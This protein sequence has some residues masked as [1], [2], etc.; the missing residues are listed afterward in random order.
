[1]YKTRVSCTFGSIHFFI[2]SILT[3]DEL[4]QICGNCLADGNH[5]V[6]SVFNAKVEIIL[7]DAFCAG[8]Q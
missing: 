1:M 4:N 8:K 5:W 7:K 3:R 6:E 2:V